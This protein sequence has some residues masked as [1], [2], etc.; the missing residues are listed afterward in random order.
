MGDEVCFLAHPSLAPIF[1]N[2]SFKTETVP[3]HMGPL[4]GIYLDHLAAERHP[5]TVILADYFSN[6]NFLHSM[7]IEPVKLLLQ[8]S[9]IFTLDI[10]D[11]QR[12]GYDID[13]FEASRAHLG[14]GSEES[15]KQRCQQEF[16]QICNK[17]KP[18][19]MAQPWGSK[20]HFCALPETPLCPSN[21]R[22]ATREQLGIPSQSKV[23][24]FCTNSW[25]HR[26][27]KCSSGARRLASVLPELI[28]DYLSHL[29]NSVHLIH[30]GPQSYDL[31]VLNAR[32]HWRPPLE[33]SEF[34]TLLAGAD[35]FLSANISATSIA[36]AIALK[37]PVLV[38]QNSISA[39]NREE[40]ESIIG[41]PLSSWLAQ[42][43]D[44]A[45][46]IFPFALWPLGFHRFLQPLLLDNPYVT[47]VEV[48]EILQQE[49]LESVL[50]SLLFNRGTRENQLSH[51]AAY[52]DQVRALP[53]GAQIIRTS[54]EA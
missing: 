14:P 36:K 20:G 32:Y 4:M 54:L 53:T 8:D 17:L 25:Q 10:W 5:T 6:A 9:A 43:L 37:V 31:P 1:S 33:P 46:P 52:L 40:A 27:Y 15:S 35:L 50:S 2:A 26:E 42:W 28:A 19:P 24:L 30:V 47:A 51:Q 11:S 23:V 7:G 38:L 22:L 16:E 29:G 34:N 39:A 41:G 48:V 49:R 13:M 12:T 21:G 3:D 44:R 45:V 18:V